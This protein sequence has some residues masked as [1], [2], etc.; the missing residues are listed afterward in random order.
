MISNNNI[1]IFCKIFSCPFRFAGR[2]ISLLLYELC[3]MYYTYNN[4]SYRPNLNSVNLC[5][6]VFSTKRLTWTNN[7]YLRVIKDEKSVIVTVPLHFPHHH[8]L[9]SSHKTCS[10]L[11]FIS[12]VTKGSL[13]SSIYKSHL[14]ETCCLLELSVLCAMLTDNPLHSF[15]Q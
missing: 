1:A 7:K 3:L 9:K 12:S 11:I 2:T 5:R 10:Y 13:L 14:V 8:K 4:I 15:L 6:K